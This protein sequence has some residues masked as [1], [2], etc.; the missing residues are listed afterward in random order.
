MAA[1][2][3]G[4]TQALGGMV[5]FSCTS[6]GATTHTD[7]DLVRVPRID[8]KQNLR[9]T[10]TEYKCANCGAFH[11]LRFKAVG[12]LAYTL[13]AP[14]FILA[15]LAHAPEVAARLGVWLGKVAYRPVQTVPPNNSFKPTPLRGAA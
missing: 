11:V 13:A 9:G 12:V 15:L 2:R 14:A 1:Q 4:L 5:K 8:S 7:R 3:P 10:T 6:C